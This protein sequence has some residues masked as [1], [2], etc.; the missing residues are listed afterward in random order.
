MIRPGGRKKVETSRVRNLSRPVKYLHVTFCRIYWDNCRLHLCREREDFSIN[1]VYSCL[2]LTA[3]SFLAATIF[4]M[5]SEAALAATLA[6]GASP[7]PALIFAT[8]GNCAG[9]AFNYGLGWHGEEKLLHKHLQ[10]KSVARAYAITQ[11]WGKWALLLSWLPVIGDPITILAGVLRINLTLFVVVTF[12]LR[13]L[14]YLF[15]V[16]I[17][18]PVF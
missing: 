2:T 17:F 15:I 16:G 10:K 8:I 1:L 4:P 18:E 14:R 3:V 7:I 11:R 6:L 12:T 13:F 5:S 9:V